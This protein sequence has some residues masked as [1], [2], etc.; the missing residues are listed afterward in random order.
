ME[1][2]VEIS[3]IWGA[4]L[5]TLIALVAFIRWLFRGPKL[6]ID[7]YAPGETSWGNSGTRKN[8]LLVVTNIGP[9]PITLEN[10]QISLMDRS[11]Y[12]RKVK[13]ITFDERSNWTPS[14]VL[15]NGK[16][17][18][19]LLQNGEAI[20]QVL[21]IFPD[22]DAVKHDLQAKVKVRGHKKLFAKLH[23]EIPQP[24]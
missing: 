2:L 5:S 7:I 9:I 17:V 16:E 1:S 14:V 15:N 4:F 21:A 22:Y 10:V 18:Q 6:A 24:T 12:R 11:I 19:N 23:S 3:A 8:L 13:S 20:R